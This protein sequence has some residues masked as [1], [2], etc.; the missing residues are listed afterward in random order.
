MT[1]QI[2]GKQHTGG[3]NDGKGKPGNLS[4]DASSRSATTYEMF[5]NPTHFLGT[6]CL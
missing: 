5:Y 3:T 6:Y 4:R 2:A 1:Q